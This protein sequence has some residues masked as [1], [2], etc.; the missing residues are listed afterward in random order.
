MHISSAHNVKVMLCPDG[1]RQP[2]Q[3][4]TEFRCVLLCLCAHGYENST[5]SFK[6]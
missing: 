4:T 2:I 1:Q 5:T 6:K 3:E